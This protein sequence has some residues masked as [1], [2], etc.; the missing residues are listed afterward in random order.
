MSDSVRQRASI[1]FSPLSVL[2]IKGPY[3]LGETYDE[4]DILA[5]ER[6]SKPTMSAV[7]C[8]CLTGSYSSE[9]EHC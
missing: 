8:F 7:D 5:V 9:E 4:C 3:N 6:M 1:P 2:A